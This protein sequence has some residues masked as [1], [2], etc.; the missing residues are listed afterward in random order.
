MQDLC[1]RFG[2]TVWFMNRYFPAVRGSVAEKHRLCVSAETKR[3]REKLYRDVHGIAV[4]LRNRNL[5]PSANRIVEHLPEGS[6]REWKAFNLAI[7]EAHKALGIS[8]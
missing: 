3:R 1:K 4:E 6:S 8:K 5:Y 2:I 7:R